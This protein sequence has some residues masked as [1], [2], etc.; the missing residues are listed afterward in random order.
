MF[1]QVL[2]FVGVFLV[3]AL[4]GVMLWF[5]RAEDSRLAQVDSRQKDY[6]I[7]SDRKA[8]LSKQISV[9]EQDREQMKI[10]NGQ[11]ILLFTEPDERIFT[12]IY[13]LTD[14]NTPGV[15]LLS[16]GNFPG[17]E[18][19][20]NLSQV[21]D[22]R[23]AG[24]GLCLGWDGKTDPY[25]WHREMLG[26]LT[27]TN[28]GE[29]HSLYFPSGA[30]TGEKAEIFA[31]LGYTTMIH[32]GEQGLSFSCPVVENGRWLPGAVGWYADGAKSM[33][34][35]TALGGGSL[36]FTIGFT[37]PQEMYKQSRFENLLS[38]AR[39]YAESH[40]FR[41]STLENAYDY[42]LHLPE[43]FA[44]GYP[45]DAQIAALQEEIAQLEEQLSTFH[46]PEDTE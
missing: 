2:K 4:L 34:K 5:A 1:R 13:P 14:R 3:V 36:I 44:E 22:L 9:L 18:G 27:A 15:L 21:D 43:P 24:W 29:V 23:K 45:Q 30:Y 28:F 38:M 11:M 7:L 35:S 20:L 25:E 42:Y 40:S 37:E 12:E 17:G 19:K 8:A 10:G 26:L 41:I 31:S 46:L 16:A 32:H 6:T 33:P 39:K